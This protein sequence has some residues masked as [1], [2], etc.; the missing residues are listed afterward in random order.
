MFPTRSL[1]EVKLVTFIPLQGFNIYT[2]QPDPCGFR[3]SWEFS[4]DELQFY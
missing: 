3:Q 2:V 4:A 1:P